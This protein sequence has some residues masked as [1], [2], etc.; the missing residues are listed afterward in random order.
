M[1]EKLRCSASRQLGCTEQYI[2]PYRTYTIHNNCI[3]KTLLLSRKL[4]NFCI[5]ISNVFSKRNSPRLNY[6]VT[7]LI[8]AGAGTHHQV[9]A[10]QSFESIRKNSVLESALLKLQKLMSLQE[11]MSLLQTTPR[12]DLERMVGCS[13]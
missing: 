2:F 6:R 4:H 13:S 12:V 1:H 7:Y 5:R 10:P 9:V 8:L 11:R 3:K